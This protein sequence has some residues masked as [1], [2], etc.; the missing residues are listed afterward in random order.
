MG[1]VT[2]VFG[3]IVSIPVGILAFVLYVGLLRPRLFPV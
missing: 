2:T 1:I 3:S